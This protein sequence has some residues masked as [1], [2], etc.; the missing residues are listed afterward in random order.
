[1]ATNLAENPIQ[2][3]LSSDETLPKKDFRDK[4]ASIRDTRRKAL[5]KLLWDAR[6]EY[7]RPRGWSGL[8]SANENIDASRAR[9]DDAFQNYRNF[10]F[11]TAGWDAAA[12]FKISEEGLLGAW[13]GK[14]GMVEHAQK[15]AVA[16][17]TVAAV[18]GPVK[19]AVGAVVGIGVQLALGKK[20]P[21]K[22]GKII[23]YFNNRG[24]DQKIAD[25]K[26]LEAQAREEGQ[27]LQEFEKNNWNLLKSRYVEIRNGRYARLAVSGALGIGAGATLGHSVA[28]EIVNDLGIRNAVGNSFLIDGAGGK[29]VE[30]FFGVKN[31]M[32]AELPVTSDGTHTFIVPSESEYSS[33]SNSRGFNTQGEIEGRRYFVSPADTAEN[34]ASQIESEPDVVSRLGSEPFANSRIEAFDDAHIQSAADGAVRGGMRPEFRDEFIA[35]LYA[36]RGIANPEMIQ[37]GPRQSGEWMLGGNRSVLGVGEKDFLLDTSRV[38]VPGARTAIV[39][40]PAER[41]YFTAE[42]SEGVLHRITILRADECNNFMQ[43]GDEIILRPT[44]PPAESVVVVP[45]PVEVVPPPRPPTEVYLRREPIICVPRPGGGSCDV[46]TNAYLIFDERGMSLA[47]AQ[48]RVRDLILG[49]DRR[50]TESILIP[51]YQGN[52]PPELRFVL[53]TYT[54]PVTGRTSYWCMSI[55]NTPGGHRAGHFSHPYIE[56]PSGR[57][58]QVRSE[59]QW[60]ELINGPGN[61]VNPEDPTIPL[62]LVDTNNNGVPDVLRVRREDLPSAVP[63]RQ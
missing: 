27:S 13:S 45:P 22:L 12:E 62:V 43:V 36:Q 63:A 37:I 3:A 20:A 18:V 40:Y 4:S 60:Q 52:I 16:V 24:A 47:E 53:M 2:R 26:V 39:T 35:A 10:L 50:G 29:I 30:E 54:D 42:D 14:L 6:V 5:G 28:T 7:A 23:G 51:N 59:A 44:P 31:A 33:G 49:E 38:S 48:E 8:R 17:P 34:A 11:E 58:I 32:A 61:V 55:E 9:Y 25:S 41:F 46:P 1:M 21:R 19:F 15:Y 57:S 56:S